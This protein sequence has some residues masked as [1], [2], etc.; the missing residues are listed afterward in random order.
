MGIESAIATPPPWPPRPVVVEGILTRGPQLVNGE[1]GRT[2]GRE[3]P[4][5][6]ARLRAVGRHAGGCVDGQ[7]E[8]RSPA[9][10]AAASQAITRGRAPG[11][12]LGTPAVDCRRGDEARRDGS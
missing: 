11:S 3:R 1:R 10:S 9:G 4:C 12:G 2:G 8:A 6:G 5:V 7:A